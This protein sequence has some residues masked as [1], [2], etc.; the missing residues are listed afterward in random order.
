LLIAHGGGSIDA[1][2]IAQQ[3]A[4]PFVQRIVVLWLS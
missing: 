2:R 4:S 3:R 1:C